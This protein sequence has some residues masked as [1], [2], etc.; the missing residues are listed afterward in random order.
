MRPTKNGET[1][2]PMAVVPATHPICWPEKC[3]AANHVPR[4]TYHAPQMK[5]WSSII[6]LKRDFIIVIIV[7]GPL[8][9]GLLSAHC[10]A[11]AT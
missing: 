4:V 1:I 8:L 7:L 5:Y 11:K 2:A 3:S 9:A 6:R 10:S